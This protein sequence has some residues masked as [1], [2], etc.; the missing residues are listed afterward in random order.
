MD[1]RPTDA[2]PAF[3]EEEACAMRLRS[4]IERRGFTRV[5]AARYEEYALLL[6]NKNFLGT[7]HM[8]TFTDPGGRLL[9]LKPDVTLS[10]VKNLPDG[11]DRRAD[12]LYYIDEVWR[13][14]E[15]N[16]SYKVLGQI[17]VEL[18]GPAGDGFADLEILDL[19]LSCLSA[20][21]GSFA[22]DVSHLG[23]VS[24]LLAQAALP[25]KL[26]SRIIANIHAKDAWDIAG[27]LDSGGVTGELRERIIRLAALHG[28]FAE[29]LERARALVSGPRMEA[30]FAEMEAI[31][32][33]LN[34]YGGKVNLD[35][36]VVNDLDYYN[37]LIFRG[38]IEGIPAVTLNGGR[39][40]NLMKRL[41][42]GRGAIG[43]AV[44]LDRLSAY[45]GGRRAADADV[46]VTYAPGCDYAGLLRA[47]REWRA[48]GQRVR[49]EQ[50][51]ADL[52]GLACGRR[53]HYD[54]TMTEVEA[55]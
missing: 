11:G 52:A 28:P 16:R 26:E 14:A 48:Q 49:C 47:V 15:E 4:L 23:F 5:Q 36:S 41:G 25:P 27:L 2:L 1:N 32:A 50:A 46:L 17:G 54:G 13:L 6:D 55:C 45:F 38:Y 29:A 10:V 21:S 30:A 33:M 3:T 34:G 12:K 40:D 44:W 31:C 18:V 7:E 37:A 9:A 51:G 8:I 43:F 20:I 42:K 53:Y 35:F 39:Y 19:A 22:L 24:G